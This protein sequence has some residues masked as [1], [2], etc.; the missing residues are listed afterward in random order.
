MS[1]SNK[2][3]LK[4]IYGFKEVICKMP[5]RLLSALTYFVSEWNERSIYESLFGL[6][7]PIKFLLMKTY[8][9]EV[10]VV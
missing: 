1:H 8:S 5:R 6:K 2:F 4:R 9:L 3:L 7:R 10:D